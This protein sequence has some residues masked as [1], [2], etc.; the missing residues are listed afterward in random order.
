MAV[1]NLKIALPHYSISHSID[2]GFCKFCFLSDC[3]EFVKMVR[4]IYIYSSEEV[5]KMCTR[6]KVTASSLEGEGTNVSSDS[7]HRAET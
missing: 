4:K 6:C 2:T 1:S 5:K 3:R 7:E